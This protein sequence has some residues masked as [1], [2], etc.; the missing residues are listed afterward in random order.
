MQ[1]QSEAN[2]LVDKLAGRLH[3][4]F[5]IPDSPRQYQREW[6]LITAYKED[7]DRTKKERKDWEWRIESL[8]EYRQR[9]EQE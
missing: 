6:T 2:Y 7:V 1:E 8:E 5:R 4:Y 3:E 9:K